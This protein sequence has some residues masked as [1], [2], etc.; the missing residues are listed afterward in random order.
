M[1]FSAAISAS[2]QQLLAVMQG[3]GASGILPP[4]KGL[5]Y[6]FLFLSLVQ[7]LVFPEGDFFLI[8][9]LTP[10]LQR[11]LPPTLLSSLLS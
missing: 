5:W 2:M 7:F 1:L 10:P 4:E 8:Q 11:R 9:D 6:I 3:P